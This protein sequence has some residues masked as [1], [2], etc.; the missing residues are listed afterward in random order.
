MILQEK[1][2]KKKKE[3]ETLKVVKAKKYQLKRNK[4][5]KYPYSTELQQV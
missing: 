4:L 2:K 5:L 3:K 1:E